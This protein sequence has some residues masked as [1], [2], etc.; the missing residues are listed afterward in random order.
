MSALTIGISLKMYF[1]RA[2]HGRW[3]RAVAGIARS[4]PAVTD[5]RARLVVLPSHPYLLEA[6]DAVRGHAG[7][8]RRPGPVLGGRGR[9]HRRGQRRATARTRLSTTSKSG[10]PNAARLFG[11]DDEI[12]RGQDRGRV[13]QRAHPVLCVG[14]QR[15]SPVEAAAAECVAQLA[16]ALRPRAGRWWWPTSRSG[17]SAPPSPH[18]RRYI[19]AV[20]TA[21]RAHL[22]VADGH[23]HLR[24]QRQARAADAA[25]RR[26]WTG[27]SSAAS[28][29]TRRRSRRYSTRSSSSRRE[30][31]NGDRPEHLRVLLAGSTRV[32]PVAARHARA[33]RRAGLRRSSRSATTRRWSR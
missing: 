11:E 28:P 27:C 21:L 13:P 8:H 22:P 10:T 2:P 26:R 6:G 15:R 31:R 30:D 14:E 20:C 3:C 18:R 1:G 17:R 23:G 9:L 16:S 32:E 5:D 19:A 12:D 4:H 24:R 29:T 33:D 7:A 25:G